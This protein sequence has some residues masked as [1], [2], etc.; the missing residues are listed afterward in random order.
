MKTMRL[1]FVI[2]SCMYRFVEGP[3]CRDFWGET[4]DYNRQSWLSMKQINMILKARRTTTTVKID[5]GRL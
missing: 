5:C 3:D 4:P 1:Y 2:M